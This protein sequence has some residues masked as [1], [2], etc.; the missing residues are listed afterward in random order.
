MQTPPKTPKG[1]KGSGPTIHMSQ[2]AHSSNTSPSGMPDRSMPIVGSLL[3]SAIYQK[4]AGS[5]GLASMDV[6]DSDIP[7][8]PGNG[9]DI[10]QLKSKR[11]ASFIV[12][13]ES[14]Q[15]KTG[16]KDGGPDGSS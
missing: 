15:R 10:T 14:S 3:N 16:K 4:A 2:K 13:G 12:S 9:L 11:E 6:D 7:L 8:T 5:P 1:K